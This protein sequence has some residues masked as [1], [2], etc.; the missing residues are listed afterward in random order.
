[1]IALT[2]R[3]TSILSVRRC[4]VFASFY[5]TRRAASRLTPPLPT[6]SAVFQQL[7]KLLRPF[8]VRP[9][10]TLPVP[11][12][13]S[14]E[15]GGTPLSGPSPSETPVSSAQTGPKFLK[16]FPDEGENIF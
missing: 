6:L 9:L 10:S 12:M 13:A 5:P 16:K 15:V 11:T 3:F 1:M 8:A 2:N 7:L 4:S 14:G